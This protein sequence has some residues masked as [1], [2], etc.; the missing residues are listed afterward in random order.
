MIENKEYPFQPFNW[1]LF[2]FSIPVAMGGLSNLIM[3]NHADYYGMA[4]ATVMLLSPLYFYI[5]TREF[6][7]GYSKV[8][9]TRTLL[10]KC[11]VQGE[12]EIFYLRADSEEEAELFFQ[13]TLEGKTVFIEDSKIKLYGFEMVTPGK[14]KATK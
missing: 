1:L 2:I 12:D 7:A 6:N 13:T 4:F 9:L 5:Q 10:F 14:L 11:R 8:T 3:G